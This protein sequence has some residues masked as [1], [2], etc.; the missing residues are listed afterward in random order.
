MTPTHNVLPVP[1]PKPSTP[2]IVFEA[3][4]HFADA[5][6][7]RRYI[8]GEVDAPSYEVAKM[9]LAALVRGRFPGASRIECVVRFKTQ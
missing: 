4:I 1:T 9:K 2:T 8:T 3:D 6:G 5:R 7:R